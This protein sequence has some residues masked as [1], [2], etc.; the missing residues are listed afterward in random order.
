MTGFAIR[1]FG[2]PVLRQRARE[3]SELDGDLVR[4]VD[5][6]RV[7]MHDARGVGLAAPAV[8]IARAK[9]R[10]RIDVDPRRV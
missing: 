5:A 7:T 9:G 3:V 1:T 6:M 8:D 4:L 2:D 10:L